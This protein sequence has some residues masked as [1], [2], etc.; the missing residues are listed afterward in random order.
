M[1]P[2]QART[3]VWLALD[4]LASRVGARQIDDVETAGPGRTIG[5]K[6]GTAGD[7]AIGEA[8]HIRPVLL[9]ESRI[10]VAVCGARCRS[11]VDKEID[12]VQ[13]REMRGDATLTGLA[14]AIV[15]G[16]QPRVLRLLAGAPELALAH[17]TEEYFLEEIRHMVY[18]GD[19]PLHLAA[20]CYEADMA[21]TL[22]EAGASVSA[23]NRRGAQA[24]HYAVDGG[25][26]NARW[27]PVAQSDTV[28]CLLQLGADP[29][30]FDKNGTAPLHRAVRNRCAAAVKSLLDGGADPHATN[31]RGSTAV[32]LARWTTGRPGTGSAEAR[33]QQQDILRLLRAA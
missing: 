11:A 5:A 4:E 30:A 16:D 33:A 28:Q 15:Q 29:N 2:K 20:A 18:A 21:R 9:V 25:P 6:C 10:N 32:Q 1:L 13:A 23:A 26:G 14:R 19:T 8:I 3:V 17:V 24:L 7:Y 31:R 22:V 12:V 27:N